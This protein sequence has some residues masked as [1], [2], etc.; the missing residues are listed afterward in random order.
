MK[1]CSL[2]LNNNASRQPCHGP[3]TNGCLVSPLEAWLGDVVKYCIV[4]LP[5]CLAAFSPHSGSCCKA[6]MTDVPQGSVAVI[7]YQPANQPVRQEFQ[8]RLSSERASS[9]RH[10]VPHTSHPIISE[11]LGTGGRVL[12]CSVAGPLALLSPSALTWPNP[13]PPGVAVWLAA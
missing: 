5:A 1:L 6:G 3:V 13:G 9:E 4:C 10:W 2:C 7:Q 11:P 12:C 8:S